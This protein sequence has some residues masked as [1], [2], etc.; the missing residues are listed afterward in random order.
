MVIGL[1]T[2]SANAWS[3]DFDKYLQNDPND[4]TKLIWTEEFE[5]QNLA[6]RLEI[7]EGILAQQDRTF[8]LSKQIQIE[9]KKI[10]TLVSKGDNNQAHL[11]ALSIY[12]DYKNSE[13]LPEIYTEFL[14]I[15]SFSHFSSLNFDDGLPVLDKLDKFLEKNP[16][17]Q[18]QLSVY[19]LQANAFIQMG[20]YAGANRIYRKMLE[21]PIYQEDE[22]YKLN[23]LTVKNNI[24]FTYSRM[25]EPDMAIDYL[26]K[27]L[28]EFEVPEGEIQSYP[29]VAALFMKINIGRSYLLKEDF[30]A[31]EPIALSTYKTGKEMGQQYAEAIGLRLLGNVAAGREQYADAAV[32]FAN[33]L[34]IAETTKNGEILG[35]F[36][37]DYALTLEE[38][39]RF[40][41]SLVLW[42]KYEEF[43]RNTRES[44]TLM[45]IAYTTA[46]SEQ[47]LRQLEL[48]TLV[49][50]S[51]ARDKIT[52]QRHIIT[53]LA[54]ISALILLIISLA[55]FKAKKKLEISERKANDASEA[56]S[57]FLANMSHEIRTPMNGVLGMTELLQSTDLDDRQKSFADTIYKSGAAL[58]TIINDILDFSKIEAGK[59]EIDPVPFN[60]KDAIEDVA[61][62]LST[63]AR[64]KEI[65]LAVRYSPDIPEHLF[66]DVG[67]IRQIV[68]NLVGNAIKFTHEGHVFINISGASEGDF[69]KLRIDVEDTGIG[70]PKD[71]LENVFHEFSQAEATTTRQFGGTGLGLAISRKLASAMQGNLTVQ[72]EYGQGSTFSFELKLKNIQQP[73][74]KMRKLPNLSDLKILVVDDL[75]INR[76]IQEEQLALWGFKV[77]CVDNGQDALSLLENAHKEKAPYDLVLLDY[78]MPDMDGAEVAKRI[79]SHNALKET[80]III[81]SSTDASEEILNFKKIGIPHY[82]TKPVKSTLLLDTIA[83]TASK[84]DLPMQ[85]E[86]DFPSSSEEGSGAVLDTPLNVLIADDNEV[87]RLVVKSFL[88]GMNTQTSFAVNGKEAFEFS[89]NMSFDLILMDV[90]M[91]EMDGM[92][93]T[94]AIRAYETKNNLNRT[95]IVC[96]TAH[97][98]AEDRKRAEDAG[99]DGYLSKPIQ[100]AKLS[101]T[102]E[103]W[104]HAKGK[105]NKPD[106]R[107]DETSQSA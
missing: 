72:S 59:L 3:Q 85:T 93:A 65:E 36:Y 49:E 87:N 58:L 84:L 4:A 77:T 40:R 11:Y 6:Q 42:K 94:K 13:V 45:R 41:E 88:D 106:A 24:G 2:I 50:E 61:T 95:P 44:K 18:T 91:P 74:R 105:T 28:S 30:T 54:V 57:A 1:L 90:S 78:H 48:E 12:N 101:E 17:V 96:L 107:S 5:Q 20:D 31:L 16:S 60:L 53:V 71:K 35:H 103:N 55:L 66:G 38:L 100:K 22:E 80:K 56:K 98:M 68:T 43:Q 75:K 81:L 46:Q 67:R 82:L 32:Y 39:G 102:I 51:I 83:L 76:D 63:P 26:T 89:Q 104:R 19:D 70:I 33:G 25:G 69:T 9:T 23:A 52:K 29:A 37:K 27:S 21:Y 34:E 10:E 92:E 8:T 64:A 62:L 15:V 7:V 99:M 73:E 97:I 79:T 47:K 14:Y 86:S